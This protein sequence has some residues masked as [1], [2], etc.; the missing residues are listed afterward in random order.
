MLFG[1][2]DE[3]CRRPRGNPSRE[4]CHQVR[5]HERTYSDEYDPK[6]R[7]TRGW[8]NVDLV[9]E[10]IPKETAEDDPDRQPDNDADENGD[11]G[12]PR[13][14]GRQLPLREAE[15]LQEGKVTSATPHR[16]GQRETER[17]RTVVL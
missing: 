5:Q 14:R 12:L 7:N 4:R 3:G 15:C 13:D 2:Q 9:S 1:S 8:H 10:E 6:D 11:A 16:G 17:G